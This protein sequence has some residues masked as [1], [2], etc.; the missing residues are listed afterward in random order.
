MSNLPR[1]RH[2]I[3]MGFTARLH[4]NDASLAIVGE[5]TQQLN[6]SGLID[7]S[8]RVDLSRL[9]DCVAKVMSTAPRVAGSLINMT[10]E[11]IDG[12]VDALRTD[13]GKRLDLYEEQL[14]SVDDFR[15]ELNRVAQSI[16][17]KT[18]KPL[19]VL[20]D[21][22]DRCR[23]TYAVDFLEVVKH[24]LSVDNVVYVFAM[25]RPELAHAVSGCYGPKFDGNGY[26]RRFFDI[27][28]K[29]PLPSRQSFIGSILEELRLRSRMPD[30]DAWNKAAGLLHAFFGVDTIGL[31]QVQQALYHSRLAL[32]FAQLDTARFPHYVE[33]LC[34][35]LIMRVYDPDMPRAFLRGEKSDKDVVESLLPSTVKDDTNLLSQRLSFE[36]TVIRAAQ[37][38]AGVNVL[39]QEYT[40]TPLL[41]SYKKYLESTSEDSRATAEGRH[42]YVIVGRFEGPAGADIL[43]GFKFAVEQLEVLE[44][45]VDFK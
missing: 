32:E 2:L 40:T 33:D 20:I 7:A 39:T 26:L 15:S 24:L 17:D 6:T 41:Q 10:G 18:G 44:L 31:R 43:R 21:E 34:V 27:E 8:N 14:A 45:L 19:I 3:Q 36:T 28:F 25:N 16:L 30:Q 5:M 12:I 29:L 13:A 11:D 35:A 37:E 38:V 22:L 1:N 23:P 9:K 42:A 4:F